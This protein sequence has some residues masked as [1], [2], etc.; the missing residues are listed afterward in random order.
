MR[1]YSVSFKNKLVWMYNDKSSDTRENDALE[2]DK[3]AAGTALEQLQQEIAEIPGVEKAEV[4]DG[5]HIVGIEAVEDDF[6]AI[7]NTV[8]N[9]FRKFD[10]SSIVTYDFQLNMQ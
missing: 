2:S 5:G 6:P 1:Y 9:L 4:S 10:D 7:M 8:V 3:A